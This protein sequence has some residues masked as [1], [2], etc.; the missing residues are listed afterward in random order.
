MLIY[1]TGDIL[2]ESCDAIVYPCCRVGGEPLPG[3]TRRLGM[4]Y[5]EMGQAVMAMGIRHLLH[6]GK[7]W[8]YEFSNS[9]IKW[10]F[11]L[12]L[13]KKAHLPVT[14]DTLSKGLVA[15]K[16]PIKHYKPKKIVIPDLGTFDGLPWSGIVNVMETVL[17]T[18]KD[19]YFSQLNPTMVVFK[20]AL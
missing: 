1:K 14:L 19:D 5:L 16:E 13:R 15:L 10:A 11:V 8:V 4:E 6:S 17:A 9:N 12:P 20:P 3:D 2:T 7:V 18:D